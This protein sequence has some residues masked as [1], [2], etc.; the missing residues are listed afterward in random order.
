MMAVHLS[1]IA[2]LQKNRGFVMIMNDRSFIICEFQKSARHTHC[3]QK[4]QVLEDVANTPETSVG[5]RPFPE[6]KAGSG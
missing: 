6:L 2:G 5:Q 4:K 1:H 3:F